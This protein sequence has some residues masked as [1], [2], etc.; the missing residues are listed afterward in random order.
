MK[1]PASKP[2]S[3]WRAIGP[4]RRR[5][6]TIG[7]SPEVRAGSALRLS[8]VAL[9]GCTQTVVEPVVVGEIRVV[10][11]RV[12]ARVLEQTRLTTEMWDHEGNP[13]TGR[14]VAW[15]SLDDGVAEVDAE[16]LVTFTGPGET[17]VTASVDGVV[18]VAHV[19]AE[20]PG[21]VEVSPGSVELRA[22][23]G[24]KAPDKR[25]VGVTNGG[26]GALSGLAVS[27]D[28]TGPDG[29][30]AAAL[31]GPSTPATLTL[32]AITTALPEGDYRADVRVEGPGSGPA[33]TVRVIYKVR[34]S[35]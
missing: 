11:P 5:N 24:G 26:D 15:V 3:R 13:L 27:I 28:Y 16:G 22:Q 7:P 9:V 18:G 12:E 34:T 35:S 32:R 23:S 1:A 14:V 4:A 31:S 17:L 21:R 19:V 20:S 29:W 2:T 6:A 25:E 10:P 8:L 30:L 33:E